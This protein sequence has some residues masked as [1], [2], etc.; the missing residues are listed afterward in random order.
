MI[1]K[2]LHLAEQD[3]YGE[4]VIAYHGTSL[5]R[6]IDTF[7]R[8]S[9]PANMTYFMPIADRLQSVVSFDLGFDEER[10]NDYNSSPRNALQGTFPYSIAWEFFDSLCDKDS[11]IGEIILRVGEGHPENILGYDAHSYRNKIIQ[12]A[13]KIGIELSK[14]DI[15][16]AKKRAGV[17]LGVSKFPFKGREYEEFDFN[18]VDIG[19]YA[20]NESVVASSIVSIYF[21]NPAMK[22]EF[23][24]RVEKAFRD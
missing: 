7:Y 15:S 10:V 5:D 6:A 11:R 2:L 20:H 14:L 19:C 8:G 24:T 16:T 1:D 9:F 18:G 12:E 21:P 4:R 17:I 3:I 23:F 13:E 22:N